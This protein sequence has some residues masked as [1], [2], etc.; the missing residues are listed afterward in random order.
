MTLPLE[1]IDFMR[2]GFLCVFFTALVEH[3]GVVQ[4]TIF[5][6]NI[7]KNDQIESCEVS[8]ILLVSVLAKYLKLYSVVL[9]FYVIFRLLSANCFKYQLKLFLDNDSSF[10]ELTLKC[11]IFI[12]SLF[13][14]FYFPSLFKDCTVLLHSGKLT[15]KWST[16]SNASHTLC[17]RV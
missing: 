7:W 11:F 15:Y 13:I 16:L 14:L 12:P 17:T 10:F 9:N 2:E 5:I 3:M 1:Y 8:W 6:W 4:C